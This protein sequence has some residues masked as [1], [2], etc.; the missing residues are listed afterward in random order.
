MAKKKAV[1]KAS[2]RKEPKAKVRQGKPQRAKG[3]RSQVLPGLEQVRSRKLDAIC[4]GISDE[5]QAMNAAKVEEKGLIAAALQAMTREGV[6]VYR[7]GGVELARVPGAEKLR[8]RLT[9]EQGD[10]DEG[11]LE[12]GEADSPS[13]EEEAADAAGAE[14]F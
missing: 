9:K 14:P 3:A 11:D 13:D 4:E 1:K 2:K 8:V 5:R 6:T 7:H 10:A 12:P